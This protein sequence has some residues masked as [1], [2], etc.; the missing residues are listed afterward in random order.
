MTI[1]N[2]NSVDWAKRAPP[3]KVELSS[4]EFKMR[5]FHAIAI[6]VLVSTLAMA[7]V[8]SHEPVS[9]TFKALD[10]NI[11]QLISRQEARADSSLN[12]RFAAVDSDAD[13]YVNE[14]ELL[15]R[16]DARDFE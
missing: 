3:A 14:A 7:D 13:G 1:Q 11:D 2:F 9:E 12:D 6:T 8:R 16:P 10:R 5:P 4:E 15:A